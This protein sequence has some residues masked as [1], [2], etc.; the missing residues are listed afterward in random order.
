MTHRPDG[1]VDPL[2]AAA[3]ARGALTRR[4]LLRRAGVLGGVLAVPG[5]A[6]ACGSGGGSGGSAASSA[7]SAAPI[8]K[9]V[10]PQW[11]FSNW[12]LYIDVDKSK[13]HP[14][15]LAFDK[16]FSTKTRYLEEINDNA[17]F[18][19]KVQA[20]LKA[21][22]SIDRDIVTLTDWM[23]GKWIQLG[24]AEK[25]DKSL[26][27]NVEKNQV[28]ALRGRP[29][30]PKD[31]YLVPWQSGLT[32]I[33]YNEK[34]VSTPPTRVSDLFNPQFKGKVTLLSEMRDTLGLTM[35]YQGVDPANATADDAKKAVDYLQ[36]YVSNGQIRQFTGND[37]AGMMANGDVAMAMVW[38]GDMVQLAADNPHLKFV[39][40]QDGCMIWTDNM[41]IP[42][43]APN[44]YNAHLWMNFYY[45]PDIAAM[46]EDY[47]NY[48]CPVNGA[49]EALMK[50]DPA[51]ANNELI[52]PPQ[53]TLDKAHVF[54]L[55]TPEEDL[56]FNQLFQQLLGA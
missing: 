24:Y 1:P 23:A 2:T 35:L 28:S 11:T 29:I 14:S 34:L 8:Q 9:T 10:A 20:Q 55:L 17:E 21:G 33:G 16:K 50:T 18:F 41:F 39:V 15:L 45:Q 12:P 42:A 46:V 13:Q 48:I 3:F 47:V 37:Y 31:E 40:P 25:L 54:K 38:S 4:D 22:Q 53:S 49:K 19:G 32:G 56:K 43:K 26:I 44:P 36:Q 27:P 52:F 7:A 51:V 5:L 30:D 6:A